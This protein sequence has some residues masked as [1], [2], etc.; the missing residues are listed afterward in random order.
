MTGT[1]TAV[2]RK[3]E[4]GLAVETTAMVRAPPG[5]GIAT[6]GA[7]RDGVDGKVRDG[8]TI[9]ARAIGDMT[10]GD[11]TT[12]AWR[13]ADATNIATA[14]AS[15]RTA[16]MI[17]GMAAIASPV[18]HT[19]AAHGKWSIAEVIRTVTKPAIITAATIV[20]KVAT[21]HMGGIT[22]IA[23]PRIIATTITRAGLIT[24]VVADTTLITDSVDSITTD[25]PDS[26]ITASVA[27]ASPL[28][29]AGI[30]PGDADS[31]STR[32]AVVD[33]P[34]PLRPRTVDSRAASACGPIRTEPSARTTC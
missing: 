9:A 21:L 25:M 13:K 22:I 26:D 14:T 8:M 31:V 10:I 2:A 7:A 16:G 30:V 5:A 11:T 3:G 17:V 18:R 1:R 20:T 23:M 33:S 27:I 28:V 34:A 6:T 4:A 15:L 12:T 32:S 29:L 19:T 24:A